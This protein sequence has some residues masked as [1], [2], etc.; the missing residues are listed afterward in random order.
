[1]APLAGTSSC[2]CCWGSGGYNPGVPDA[3]KLLSFWRLSPIQLAAPKHE[4]YID[5]LPEEVQSRTFREGGAPRLYEYPAPIASAREVNDARLKR[6]QHLEAKRARVTAMLA[7]LDKGKDKRLKEPEWKNLQKQV[8]A[9][10]GELEAVRAATLFM[11]EGTIYELDS[12]A[13]G[14]MLALAM[15]DDLDAAIDQVR[16]SGRRWWR[17]AAQNLGRRQVKRAQGGG[18]ASMGRRA[19]EQKTLD[20]LAAE[21]DD[22]VRDEWGAWIK[23]T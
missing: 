19:R 4:A 12:D 20:A 11:S 15:P 21:T 23:I 22:M 10:G 16:V 14:H 8:Q 13:E 3:R 6:L 9:L 18:D 5:Q 1:M 7:L 17:R 2:D